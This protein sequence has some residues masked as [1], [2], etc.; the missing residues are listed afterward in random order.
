MQRRAQDRLLASF[1]Q[2]R[3]AGRPV[4]AEFSASGGQP[5][6]EAAPHPWQLPR[7]GPRGG[8]PP[9]RFPGVPAGRHTEH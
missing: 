2:R 7:P 3:P 1:A 4:T 5:P 6:R 8:G 9:I